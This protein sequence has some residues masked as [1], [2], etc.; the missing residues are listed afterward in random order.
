[1]AEMMGA[2]CEVR[3]DSCDMEEQLRPGVGPGEPTL[4]PSMDFAD[5][6]RIDIA[7]R[8]NFVYSHR[9]HRV[10]SSKVIRS[11]FSSLNDSSFSFFRIFSL[12]RGS[13]GEKFNKDVIN[14]EI[15]ILSFTIDQGR[16]RLA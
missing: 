5:A 13:C 15:N 14:R 10:F 7:A 1:M 16:R 2:R 12:S 9:S 4:Y 6:T 11:A 8:I 3:D